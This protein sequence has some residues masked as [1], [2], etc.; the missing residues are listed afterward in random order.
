MRKIDRRWW[1]SRFKS[2]MPIQDINASI[3]APATLGAPWSSIF[4]WHSISFT[5]VPVGQSR[6]FHS[7]SNRFFSVTAI[8]MSDI[9]V[10]FSYQC[11]LR[12][13]YNQ[14]Y[15][16]SRT[17]VSINTRTLEGDVYSM[18]WYQMKL[19]SQ[20]LLTSSINR[21]GLGEMNVASW[22]KFSPPLAP[23]YQS[24]RWTRNS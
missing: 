23:L 9:P 19:V 1:W 10:G 13:V 5:R 22:K 17:F 8:R 7:Y 14:V 21:L 24:L 15:M 18:R 16:S 4:A 11:W 12:R 3:T 2:H 20:D 6:K